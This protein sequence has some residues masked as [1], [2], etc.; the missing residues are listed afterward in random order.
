M[1]HFN[2]PEEDMIDAN[3]Y[4]VVEIGWEYNDEYYYRPESEGGNPV[5]AFTIPSLAEEYCSTKD[6]E[7]FISQF[8]S[9]YTWHRSNPANYLN[10]GWYGEDDIAELCKNVDG[11]E[12]DGY[13]FVCEDPKRL[14]YDQL[15]PLMAEVGLCRYEVVAVTLTA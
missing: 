8:E 13:K 15:H 4:V 11:L 3:I 2:I 7:W 10:E 9:K 12:W 5:N 1:A 6:C 14:K